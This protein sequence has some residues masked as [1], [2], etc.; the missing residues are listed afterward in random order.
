VNFLDRFSKILQ[1]KISL[2]FLQWEPNSERERER[3][4]EEERGRERER[5]KN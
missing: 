1:N 3:E 4:R 5:E 2:K